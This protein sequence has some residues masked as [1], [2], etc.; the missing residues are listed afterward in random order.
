MARRQTLCP[1]DAQLCLRL[2][3]SFAVCIHLYHYIVQTLERHAIHLAKTV[4][5]C[6]FELIAIGGKKHVCPIRVLNGR[7]V[8][9]AI[10]DAVSV[11]ERK[12]KE[13]LS[14]W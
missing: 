3:T 12:A 10:E 11:L 6:A 9:S 2:D 14:S 4:K 8:N 1:L 5:G 7:K 13:E